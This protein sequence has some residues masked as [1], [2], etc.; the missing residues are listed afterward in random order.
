MRKITKPMESESIALSRQR[1]IYMA[2][3]RGKKM[4]IPFTYDALVEA[5]SEVMSAPAWAY[6]MGAA[7]A[8]KTMHTNTA[9]FDSWKILPRVLRDVGGRDISTSYAGKSFTTPFF[10]CP[11]GSLGLV[12]AKADLAAARAAARL[13]IPFMSSN[14]SSVSMED[15]S[16]GM[17]T[18]PKMFQLYWSNSDELVSSFIQRAEQANFDALVVT[19]DN[20]L[21][22]WRSRDLQSAYLPYLHGHGL[23]HYTSDP[24]FRQLVEK[25]KDKPSA[26]GGVNLKVISALIQMAYRHPGSTWANLRSGISL[27]SARKFV[28]VFMKPSLSWSDIRQLRDMTQLPIVVKGIQHPEDAALAVDAG[29]NTIMVS[30]HGGRQVDGGISSLDAL[31]GVMDAVGG[32]VDVLFDSGIR[33]GMDAFK[34]LALGAKAVGIGRPFVLALALAGEQGVRDLLLNYVAEFEL[35]MGL[36]GCSTVQEITMDFLKR[37]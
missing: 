25:T 29:V 23:A 11:V 36:S 17:G 10:I 24:V 21:L 31:V 32:K 7:G 26:T 4:S 2:G 12:H 18:G 16:Q 28:D 14:Q 1:E 37:I 19:V 5:A 15:L 35:T 34:A 27:K 33:S 30:N 22:G 13:G 3:L 8:E 6:V 9:A 20:T